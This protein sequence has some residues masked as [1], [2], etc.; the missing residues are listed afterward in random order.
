M[1]KEQKAFLPKETGS[2]EWLEKQ[3]I[4]KLLR[5]NDWN[6]SKTAQKLNISRP[7]LA[8]KIKQ[9]GIVLER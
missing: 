8:A 3:H 4:T 9:Y 6:R 1:T 5:E 7:T 2:L